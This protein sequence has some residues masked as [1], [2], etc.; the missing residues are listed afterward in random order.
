MENSNTGET[1]SNDLIA[2]FQDQTPITILIQ[3]LEQTSNLVKSDFQKDT[4]LT[5]VKVV[6]ESYPERERDVITKFAFDFYADLS[7]QMKVPENLI[8]EN[9]THAENYFDSKFN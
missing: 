4:I 5:I 1:T 2:K 3:D 7:R 9:L 6:K 8:S